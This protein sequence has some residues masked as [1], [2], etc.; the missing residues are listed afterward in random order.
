MTTI[1]YTNHHKAAASDDQD[2]TPYRTS[3]TYMTPKTRKNVVT[4]VNHRIAYTRTTSTQST[5]TKCIWTTE[6][7]GDIYTPTPEMS[8]STHSGNP[9]SNSRKVTDQRSTTI[10]DQAN[11]LSETKPIGTGTR[12]LIHPRPYSLDQAIEYWVN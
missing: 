11:H 10:S 5:N 4:N 2:H 12:R 6:A 3:F 7:D 9:D 1:W 8:N